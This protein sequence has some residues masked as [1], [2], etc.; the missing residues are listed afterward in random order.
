[1]GPVSAILGV[2][3]K[4]FSILVFTNGLK[5]ESFM[6]PPMRF[7]NSSTTPNNAIE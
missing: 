6:P 5:C 3:W 2:N 7:V 1:M 4:A